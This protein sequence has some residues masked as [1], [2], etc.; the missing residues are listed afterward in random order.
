M[1]AFSSRERLEQALTRIND[2][3]DAARETYRVTEQQVLLDAANAYMNLLRDGAV[4]DLQR[5]NVEVLSK[6]LKQ[7]RDR[8]NVGELTRTDVVEA[9]SRLAPGRSQLLAA[10]GREGPLRFLPPMGCPVQS[11]PSC[12]D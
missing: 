10:C 5:R 3:V 4:L 12:A 11:R 8:F 9:E 1:K 6:Q 7:M 2:P